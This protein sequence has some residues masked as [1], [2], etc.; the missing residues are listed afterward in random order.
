MEASTALLWSWL[1]ILTKKRY[2]ALL[3][4]YGALEKA[5][6]YLGEEL[7]KAL[8]CRDE[9]VMK[10]VSRLEE[11]DVDRY[12]AELT[13]RDLAIIS[14]DDDSYPALLKEIGDPPVFLMYRGDLSILSSPCIG[15]VG[16]REMSEYGRRVTEHFVPRFAEAQM[17][18]VSGLAQ[19]IDAHVAEETLRSGGKTVAVLGHGLA[20]IYPKSN[21]ALAES[22]IASGG[23]IMSEFPLDTIPD[24][25]TFP[26]RNRIIAGLCLGT[27]V[28]EAGEGSGAL[29]TADL[30][31]DYAREVFAVPGQIFDLNYAGCHDI[32]SRGLAK[33]VTD[34]DQVLREI[35]IVAS[36]K[37]DIHIVFETNEEEQLFGALT[38]MPQDVSGIVTKCGLQAAAI[39]ATLTLL[40]LKGV[41]KNVGNGR[42]VRI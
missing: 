16:T 35:G 17:V 21:A 11:F 3:E 36:E 5:T 42:W 18:T 12:Q 10:A 4:Q 30:A 1:G 14:I 40:E 32:L 24:K 22:I 27:V 34:P 39:N 33:L 2:D 6:E 38:T 13:K 31:L 20:Q 23:L 19:G 25:H 28:L 41:A 9:T 7:F 37:K 29:I 26:A 8:G 15:L